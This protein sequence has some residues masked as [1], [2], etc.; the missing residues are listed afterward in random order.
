[1]TQKVYTIS[2]PAKFHALWLPLPANSLVFLSA[3]GQPGLP[4]PPPGVLLLPNVHYTT[5]G[6]QFFLMPG[7]ALNVN[8]MV[9]VVTFP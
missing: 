5:N 6:G 3:A 2:D 9:A 7:I 1:M 8:D 4:S